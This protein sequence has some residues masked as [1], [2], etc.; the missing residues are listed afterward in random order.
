M[1]SM[2][3]LHFSILSGR[4][5]NIRICNEESEEIVSSHLQ[6][7]RHTNA[8]MIFGRAPFA[9]C[10]MCL[11]VV[12]I[13]SK[14]LQIFLGWLRAADGFFWAA[15]YLVSKMRSDTL[16]F[17]AEKRQQLLFFLNFGFWPAALSTTHK[18]VIL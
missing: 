15:F 4:F 14:K 10:A 16:T 2:L 11:D 1:R 5:D 13:N 12:P 3:K 18:L 7:W 8:E 6:N 9:A 17:P